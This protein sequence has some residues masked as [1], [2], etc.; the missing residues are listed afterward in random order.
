MKI[1]IIIFVLSLVSLTGMG[2]KVNQLKMD[3]WVEGEILFGQI[4]L[5]GLQGSLCSEWFKPEF[6]AY[7]IDAN[8]LS[9]LRKKKLSGLKMKLILGTWCHD[10]HQQ[11]PR[12]IKLFEAIKFPLSNLEMFAMDT[13]K[14]APG[15]DIKALDVKLVPTLIIYKGS[16]EL[17]RI[18]ESPKVSLEADLLEIL[19]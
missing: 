12:L 18:I 11:V 3:D 4:N 17:G 16:R 8:L 2:Q 13:Y 14:K 1:Q 7:K 6:E 9:E 10:S 19:K 5:E 15:I